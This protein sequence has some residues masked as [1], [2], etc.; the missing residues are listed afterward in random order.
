MA[1]QKRSRQTAQ[2]QSRLL[3]QKQ[4]EKGSFLYAILKN[5]CNTLAD[6]QCR[7][8]KLFF[9][10]NLTILP[11]NADLTKQLFYAY[12]VRSSCTKLQLLVRSHQ[13]AVPGVEVSMQI[14]P[15][16]SFYVYL[17][18][19]QFLCISHQTTIFLA[20]FTNLLF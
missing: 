17:I 13:T 3:L 12:L 19:L 14:S 2:T 15:F 7:S 18:K 1:Y 6:P 11:F 9:L 20:E 4:S 5:E 10:C 16:C 8:H